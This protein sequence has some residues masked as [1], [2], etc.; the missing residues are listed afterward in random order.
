MGG[1]LSQILKAML[2][3]WIYSF[4]SKKVFL[5]KSVPNQNDLMFL[6]DRVEQGDI[7]PILERIIPLEEVPNAFFELAKGH[8]RGKIIVAI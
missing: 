6:A 4:S 2:F 1:S 8:A 5:L 7:R 3:G